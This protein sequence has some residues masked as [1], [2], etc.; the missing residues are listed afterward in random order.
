M[1]PA[2]PNVAV[3]GQLAKPNV[4]LMGSQ[5]TT[6]KNRSLTTDLGTPSS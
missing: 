1:N 5:E 6:R 4:R 3:V 2:G